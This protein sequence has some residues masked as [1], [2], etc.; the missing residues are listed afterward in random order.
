[1][2][3]EAHSIDVAIVAQSCVL[4]SAMSPGDFWKICLEGQ[5]LFKPISNHRLKHYLLYQTNQTELKITSHLAS[6]ITAEQLRPAL[7]DCK[8]PKEKRN[9]LAV[10]S[11]IAARQLLQQISPGKRGQTQDIIVGCMNPDT[12]FELQVAQ[13]REEAHTAELAS[14]L[15]G[16]AEQAELNDLVQRSLRDVSQTHTGDKDHFFTT[17]ILARMAKDHQLSGEQLLV[18]SACASSLA[19]FDLAV[20]RLRLGLSDFVVAGGFESNLGQASYMIFSSVG[21]LAPQESHPFCKGSQGLVQSEGAVLF[22]L[23]RLPDA[24]RDGDTIHAVIKATAGSGDGRSASLFQPNKDGQIRAYSKVYG[25]NRRLDY[26]E[27]HGTGTE[28]GDQTEAASITE[29]FHEQRLPV[30]SVKTLMGHTKG[31][32]GA[33][34]VLKAL[35]IIQHRLVP[36]TP[37]HPAENLFA[38]TADG[39]YLNFQHI[40]LSDEQ[41]IRI[42][43][44]AFGFGGT[45]YHILLEEFRTPPA[46]SPQPSPRPSTRVGL[47]AENRMALEGF[48]REDFFKYDCP[49]KLPPKSAA[50]I[51]KTQLAGILTAWNAIKSLGPLWKWIP[52][53]RINVVSACSLGLDQVFEIA[54]RLIFEAVVRLGE[55]ENPQ[56][57]VVKKLRAHV[58]QV[59]GPRYAPINEDAATGVLNNVIAGRICNLFDLHGK[60]YNIDKDTASI[61]A[62]LEMIHMELQSDPQQV[63]VLVGVEEELPQGALKPE[64]THVHAQIFTS[65][66]F[67]FQHE[68]TILKELAP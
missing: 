11:E 6:E 10:Y 3:K 47:L 15:Q 13:E 52:K 60:S 25:K 39:P 23:K 58:D 66:T 8:L 57:P 35:G 14:C 2:N 7:A 17:S 22:A 53:D 32:A 63:F 64:R 68:L 21:A 37:P 33:T 19:A 38:E 31:A 30:G 55:S 16:E 29:F 44:N 65:E 46:S 12:L 42:G 24:L 45:N 20:Q 50:G 41:P 67:A 59:V 40:P 43:V 48:Q 27:A 28:V 18:D 1:M 5:S 54:D 9:R 56:S 49:I 34:S 51:D 4:P 36:A 61:A 62:A 26:L